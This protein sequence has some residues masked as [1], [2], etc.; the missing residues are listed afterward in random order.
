MKTIF[1]L[2]QY[3]PTIKQV[4]IS[5]GYRVLEGSL[6]QEGRESDIV[7]SMNYHPDAAEF[8]MRHKKKYA[9]WIVD[10][11]HTVLYSKTFY[12]PSNYIFLFD[13]KQY[14]C[15]KSRGGEAHVFYLPLAADSAA[16]EKTIAE[17]RKRGGS[18]AGQGETKYQSDV[19]FVGRLYRD[20]DHALFDAIK[21]LPPYVEGYLDSLMTIQ[22]KIWGADILQDSISN[23]VWAQLK[24]HVRWELPEGYDDNYEETMLGVIQQK[25]AQQERM[26]LCSLLAKEF[27]FAL[28]TQDKTE[29]APE[30]CN[31]GYVDYLT[32]MPLVF[33]NSKINVNLTLRSIQTG[34][35][36]RCLDIMACGG[37]LLTNYQEEISEYFEDGKEVVIYQDFND[38]KEKIH[39]YLAHEEERK[40]IAGRGQEKV[41]KE[42]SYELQLGSLLAA[43]EEA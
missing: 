38:M 41:R 30:I 31:R 11:P 23:Q 4:L 35:P 32:E 1:L 6:E 10:S 24:K 27:D 5:K 36:L 14:C 18:D 43:V 21:F 8:C 33:A 16:F 15:M 9:S 19:S 7:F 42:F 37:F 13:Y 34:I 3:I 17:A 25:I 40:E 28:Y 12:Y 26:E 39:Y 29:F 22:R 2:E 20:S